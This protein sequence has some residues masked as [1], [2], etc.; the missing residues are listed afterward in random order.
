VRIPR[1]LQDLQ[2]DRESLLLDFSYQRLFQGLELFFR[3]RRQQLSFRAVVSG[4]ISCD[5]EGQGGAQVLMTSSQFGSARYY[6]VRI[7]DAMNEDW[8]N[9]YKLLQSFT[10]SFAHKACESRP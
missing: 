10:W 3:Q 8:Q 1:S 6:Y 4:A 5:H 2:V 7:E 9:P